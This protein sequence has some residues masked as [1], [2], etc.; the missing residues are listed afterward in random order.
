MT[1]PAVAKSSPWHKEAVAVGLLL[2]SGVLAYAN[3]FQCPFQLDDIGSITRNPTI[4]PP[5]S[6]RVLWPRLGGETA[7]GRPFFN[8]TLAVNRA[9]NGTEV[10]G[11]HAGNL[12]CHLLAGLVLYALIRGTLALPTIPPWLSGHG[13][14]LSLAVALLWLVHPL[15]TA[16][17]T[18]VSQRCEILAGL[19]YLLTLLFLLRGHL[20]P[21]P[22]R[23][24]VGC[25]MSCFLGVASKEIVVSAP[26]VALLYDRAFLSGS[27][28]EALRRRRWLYL[29]LFLTWVP[30]GLFMAMTDGR[31]GTAGLGTGVSAVSYFLAQP[32]WIVHYLRLCVFP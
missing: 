13:W 20:S 12:I 18:Y 25:V 10:E 26:V 8:L 9:L 21:H 31:G 2:M 6:W 11:Y 30:L 1:K 23:W 29:G 5:L 3:S 14:E 27:L 28:R 22:G 16:A 15:Q 24:Y 19:F 17:V 7:S 32:A 4:Q